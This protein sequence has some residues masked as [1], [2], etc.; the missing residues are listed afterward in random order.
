MR[1]KSVT[2]ISVVV[3]VMMMTWYVCVL[4]IVSVT[5][6][7]TGM[8]CVQGKGTKPSEAQAEKQTTAKKD[9]KVCFSNETSA[10]QSPHISLLSA[11]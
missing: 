2:K 11:L 8:S 5:G 6:S 7:V 9:K 1:P 10:C 3:V 4:C